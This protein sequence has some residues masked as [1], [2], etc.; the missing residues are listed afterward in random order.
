MYWMSQDFKRE[1]FNCQNSYTDM[2]E[3]SFVYNEMNLL[4]DV[5]RFKKK[6]SV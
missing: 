3:F 2:T 4:V 6:E 1:M 5:S